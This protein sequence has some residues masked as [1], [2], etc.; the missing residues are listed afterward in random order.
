MYNIHF[1]E[2][3]NRGAAVAS[4]DRRNR[5]LKHRQ[6]SL[7]R[8]DRPHVLSARRAKAGC[9][10]HEW[11][12]GREAY[13]EDNITAVG[14]LLVKVA[15]ADRMCFA[16]WT[17][18]AY[19]VECGRVCLIRSLRE[20]QYWRRSFS[21]GSPWEP[22]ERR[23]FERFTPIVWIRLHGLRLQHLPSRRSIVARNPA[24]LRTTFFSR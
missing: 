14:R 17:N 1:Q 24:D 19:P 9:S 8:F 16:I 7:F 15:L 18:S 5:L 10:K 13:R 6:H 21:S 22:A 23:L 4:R 20:S 2:S 3:Q 11:L 12:T